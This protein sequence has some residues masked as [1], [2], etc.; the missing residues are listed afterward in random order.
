MMRA[1]LCYMNKQFS[2]SV[3]RLKPRL[4]RRTSMKLVRDIN[5]LASTLPFSFF[6]SVTWPTLI[7]CI[8]T[9]YHGSWHYSLCQFKQVRKIPIFQSGLILSVPTSCSPSTAMCAGHYLRKTSCCSHCCCLRGYLRCT[10]NL[11][12]P[13]GCSSS[14]VNPPS[15]TSLFLTADLIFVLCC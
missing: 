6:V 7:P 5:H 4:L 10:E 15:F 2:P 12:S 8:S 1:C 11:G 13:N 9:V 3:C 14:Q